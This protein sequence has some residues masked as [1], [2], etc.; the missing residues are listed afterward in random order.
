MSQQYQ[1]RFV[2]IP[3]WLALIVGVLSIAFAVALFLLSLTVFLLVLP[4]LAVAGAL[5]YFFGLPR[6]ARHAR[7][8]AG[9]QIIE[10]EY[11]VV[12]SERIGEN[13]R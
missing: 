12:R 1:I 7:R 8:E 5:Y 11:R 4:V 6:T 9:T 3:R 10:G 13:P 2:Q